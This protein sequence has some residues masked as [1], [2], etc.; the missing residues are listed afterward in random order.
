MFRILL[1]FAIACAFAL[2]VEVS[3]DDV[4][5]KNGS[6]TFFAGDQLTRSIETEA[7]TFMAARTLD[8]RGVAGG[9]LHVVGFDVA[10][11]ADT[12]DDLYAFGGTVIMRGTVAQ[13]LTAGGFSIR[14]DKSAQTAGN[15]RLFGN[16]VTVE[17]PVTGALFVTG[18]DVILNAP[19]EGDVFVAAQT[20]SFGPDAVVGG[21]LTYSTPE[22]LLVPERVADDARV[23]FERYSGGKII[24]EWEDVRK[25][26]PAF[27]TF[28][29]M[30]FGF[31]LSLF[32]FVALAALM[33]A[34]M[35]LRL[36]RMRKSIAKAPGQTLMLGLV[37]LSVLFGLV[38][39]IVLTIVGIPFVPIV[40]L[41]I[42]VAWTLGYA[43]G[44]YSVAMRIWSGLGG[45][46]DPSTL[47]RLLVFAAAITAI[48]LLNYIPFV[49]WVANYTLVL[50]GLG[51]MTRA[52]F[53]SMISTPDAVFNVDMR[54]N[55]D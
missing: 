31:F 52:L 9:D 7:D 49:G 17:G 47:A 34:F 11:T 32:F 39:I 36:A 8:A 19:I 38:P 10:I 37:G 43:L 1:I 41:A 5:T 22:K 55:S 53:Q 16:T 44:A 25:D 29:S 20:L 35:P 14:T 15:A 54:P 6:D 4:S 42:V 26:M 30:M 24:A 45:E 18:R 27:P 46:E 40:L 51:A 28:A 23:T 48:A 13:D 21:A 33:L 12:K 3:A 2:P 50:L